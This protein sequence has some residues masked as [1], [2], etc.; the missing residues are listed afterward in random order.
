MRKSSGKRKTV[1][2]TDSKKQY[3]QI[4]LVLSQTGSILSKTLKTVTKAKYNHASIGLTDDMKNMYSFGRVHL[5][6][7]LSGG[8]VRE[9]I[10]SGMFKR[11]ED[12]DA[13]VFMINIP[14]NTYNLIQ[15]H[16]EEMYTNKDC[17]HYNKA[18]LIT[19]FF[20]HHHQ[21]ENY[22]YCSDFVFEVLTKFEIIPADALSGIVKPI[23]FYELFKSNLIF[24][25]KFIDY[26]SEQ[27]RE[28]LQLSVNRI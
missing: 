20:G 28:K 17:Y 7:P 12:T 3:R 4:Y 18:G 1:V 16:L 27:V 14:E 19:A 23:D 9:S 8:Y 11:F 2:N 26:N 5:Y 21:K 6:N 22:Y 24:E 15:N 13:A 25:G 10:D